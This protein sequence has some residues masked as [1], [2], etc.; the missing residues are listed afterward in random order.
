MDFVAIIFISIG[1][2]MDAFTVSITCGINQKKIRLIHATRVALFFGIAQGVMPVLGWFIGITI[3]Q[4]IA[5]FDHWVA[6]TLLGFIGVKMIWEAQDHH[7]CRTDFLNLH[8]LF[9]LALATSIDAF[10]VGLSFALLSETVVIP[11]IIIGVI[12]FI[13]SLGGVYLGDRIGCLLGKKMEIAGGLILI[14]IGVKILIEHLVK[15]I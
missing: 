11:A 4:W 13:M 2:A 7:V 8:V 3:E 5:A 15:G 10:A 1:L 9:M 6:F 14:G 12:T